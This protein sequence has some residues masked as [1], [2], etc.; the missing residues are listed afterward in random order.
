[1]ISFQLGATMKYTVIFIMLWMC[2]WSTAEAY[3]N[4]HQISRVFRK[5]HQEEVAPICLMCHR[6]TKKLVFD[7]DMS[8]EFLPEHYVDA[9]APIV[10]DQ[11]VCMRCHIH[12]DQQSVNH[13]VG[14]VYDINH[15]S[16]RFRKAP[17]G[18][19]LYQWEEGGVGRVMCS[20]CHN[21]H[22][23]DAWMLRVSLD[24][25]QLCLCCHDY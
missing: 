8:G 24:D 22:S 13:P 11:G 6:L 1:M 4:P 12:A 7:F 25:S 2:C 16:N 15:L 5:S 23:D 21:P 9:V 10:N 3:Q 14:M 20:T 18:I 19:K 17:Q